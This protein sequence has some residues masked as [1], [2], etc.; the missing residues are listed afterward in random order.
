MEKDR[1]KA[2]FIREDDDDAESDTLVAS[3]ARVMASLAPRR[4]QAMALSSC[5]GIRQVAPSLFLPA[6]L[7]P[8]MV[9]GAD[10]MEPGAMISRR[11]R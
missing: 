2:R 11:R 4:K 6:M 3:L 7:I 8:Q 9:L 5:A 10:V 1:A